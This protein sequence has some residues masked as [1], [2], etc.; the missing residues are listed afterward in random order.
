MKQL[1]IDFIHIGLGKCA[2]TY[3]QTVFNNEPDY[4][5]IDLKGVVES[6]HKNARQG[7]DPQQFPNININ[8][9]RSAIIED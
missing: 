1:P 8:I 6:V 9:D 7:A 3:L 2:S 5:I 4:N